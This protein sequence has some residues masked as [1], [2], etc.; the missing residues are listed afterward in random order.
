M[1]WYI[2]GGVVIITGTI[3]FNL[4]LQK[5]RLHRKLLMVGGLVAEWSELNSMSKRNLMQMI[6]LIDDLYLSDVCC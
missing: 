6:Y 3:A 2:S 4:V 5:L 1:Y